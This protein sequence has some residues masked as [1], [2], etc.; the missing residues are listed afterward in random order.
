MQLL[1]ATL[2]IAAEAGPVAG[3]GQER[4]YSMVLDIQ[5]ERPAKRIPLVRACG[6]GGGI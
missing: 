4:A 1:V 2:Y 6:W 5:F 3:K